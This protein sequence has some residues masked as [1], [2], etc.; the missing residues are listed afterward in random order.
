MKKIL[1]IIVLLTFWL[2]GPATAQRGILPPPQQRQADSLQR[3]LAQPAGA[4]SA[5]LTRL[6]RLARLVLTV[7]TV[8]AGGY[9]Q[10]ARALARRPAAGPAARARALLGLGQ[11]REKAGAVE[12]AVGLF[13]AA[14]QQ[15]RLAGLPALESRALSRRSV[16]L[17]RLGRNDEA[18]PVALQA[19]RRAEVSPDSG[20]VAEAH[21]AIGRIHLA[22]RNYPAASRAFAQVLRVYERQHD[23]R[24]QGKALNMLGIVARDAQQRPQAAAY[25]GRGL[26]AYRSLGDSAGVAT[27]LV[28]LGVL[29]MR[30]FTKESAARALLPLRRAERIYNELGFQGPA[31]LADLYSIMAANLSNSGKAAAGLD[32]AR[33]SLRMAR[34]SGDLQEVADALEG[35]GLLSFANDRYQEAYEYEHQ[36]KMV[37][38]TIQSVQAAAKMAEM[39]TKY[40]TEKKEARNQLQATQLHVQQQVIGRRN[41]QLGAGAAVAAL[42]LLVGGLLFNRHRLRLRVAQEQELQAR[43]RHRA[44]AVL[45][46]EATERQ[47]IGLDLHDG[48]GQVLTAAKLNLE[49]LKEQYTPADPGLRTLL[50]NALELVD[51]S[52]REVRDISHN[53]MPNA[54]IKRGLAQAV[55]DFLN[56]ITPD[57]RLKINLEV[58][59]LDARRLPLNVENVLFRVIQEL[60]Q[61]IVKHARAT[62]VTLQLVRGPEDLTMLVEDNGV[63]FDP[64]ALDPETGGIGLKNIESRLEYLGGSVY[65]DSRPGRGTTVTATVPLG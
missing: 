12:R 6:L 17:K 51:E 61:N 59:G 16:A 33:R 60:V 39:Q 34:Q 25:F 2:A 45:E 56:K 38:D 62:E 57:G 52:F 41:V 32:Y 58:V 55:R 5:R 28:S 22:Q 63:G 53:L 65:F 47:R 35:L 23:L 64:A 36:A 40:E 27:V 43:D 26:A 19:L 7:D 3:L 18:M 4:D 8:R 31:V 20:A 37:G 1:P 50:Q 42:L 14:Q 44:A 30:L 11:V 10:Q 29:E 13:A 9:A 24:G 54:L 48:V 21:D 46:A 15:A 49:A